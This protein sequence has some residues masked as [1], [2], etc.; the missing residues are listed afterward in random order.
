MEE[1]LNSLCVVVCNLK[2]R[3]LA[4]YMSHGMI[5]CA[6]TPDRQ[7]AE[8]LQP[9]EGSQPGD[10]ISFAGFERKPL[11]ELPAKKSPW[12]T[13]E[14]NLSINAAGVAVYRDVAFA[15][16]KGV[17]KSKTLLNGVIH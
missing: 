5:L 1:I 12:E 10:L 9:P 16:E 11:A 17:V 14:P 2:A 7:T 6:E 15:T 3:K 8:L 13:V 4:D